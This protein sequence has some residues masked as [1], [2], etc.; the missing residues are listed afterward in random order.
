MRFSPVASLLLILPDVAFAAQEGDRPPNLL[1][2]NG[3]LMFWTLIIFVGLL[4]VLSRYAFKPLL[5]AVEAREQALEAAIKQAQ[6]DREDATKLLE[7]QRRLLEAARV[8]AQRFVVEGRVTGE[9]LR[10][11]MLEE[12]RAQQ[13]ELLE[14]ARRDIENEKVKAIAELRQEAIDLALAAAGKIIERNLDE[15]GNR[16]LV[17][18]FLATIP[19]AGRK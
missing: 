9:K 2:P 19:A 7:E 15:T 8:E 14:R 4:F 6:R 18:D 13:Q 3:G 17:E 5:A 10:A 12:T 11:S 16:R 1:S